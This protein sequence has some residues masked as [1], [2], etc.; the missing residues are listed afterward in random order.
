MASPKEHSREWFLEH[1]RSAK[2]EVQKLCRHSPYLFHEYHRFISAKK[3]FDA[4]KA[5]LAV[6]KSAWQKL[7]DGK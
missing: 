1:Q 7:K 3:A 4:A 5:E 2:K 6:A